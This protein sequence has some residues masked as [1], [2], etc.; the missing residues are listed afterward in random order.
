MKTLKKRQIS[1]NVMFVGR[2]RA[3][4]CDNAGNDCHC[5]SM[6]SDYV[7]TMNRI[8]ERIRI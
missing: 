6:P 7:A 8:I 1:T 3:D 2:E 4:I 5:G